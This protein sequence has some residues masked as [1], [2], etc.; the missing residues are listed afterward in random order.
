MASNALPLDVIIEKKLAYVKL[1]SSCGAPAGSQRHNQLI[2]D[3]FDGIT[4]AVKATRHVPADT[5]LKIK[6]LLD[7]SFTSGQTEALMLN[8]NSKVDLAVV[9]ASGSPNKSKG[10][11]NLYL[12]SYLKEQ[13]WLMFAKTVGGAG[14][15]SS[16]K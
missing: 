8:I 3:A 1:M 16:S 10:Q 6:G 9:T 12:D 4:R 2:S 13:Q 5:A 11:S 7:K 15:P 14:S